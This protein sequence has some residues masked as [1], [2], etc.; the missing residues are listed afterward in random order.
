MTR[1]L[2][3]GYAPVHFVCFKPLYDS[4]VGEPDIE[5]LVSGG[6][7]SRSSDG[8][9][10]HD[11]AAMYDQFDLAPHTVVDAADVGDLDVDILFCSNTKPIKPHSYAL[12]VEMFHGLSFRNRAVRTERVSYDR[13]FILGP[14]QHR[15]LLQRGVI[16]DDAAQGV[17][18]GFPKTDRLVDGSLSRASTLAGLGLSGERSVVLY[19]PTG[20]HENSLET[21]GEELVRRLGASSE[22]DLLVKPHDHAKAAI[23][24][25]D[26]LAPLETDHV[27]LLRSADVIPALHAADLLISD[28]SSIANEYLLLDRPLVFLDV[29]ELLA[30]AADE[31]DR[32]DLDTWGRKGGLVAQD[33]DEA[34]RAIDE[35]LS[36]PDAQSDTRRAIAGDLF[37][38]PGTATSMAVDRLRTEARLLA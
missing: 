35:G 19:A 1:I 32:L 10:H 15:R 4:L 2:F 17:P 33:V 28:A 30:A 29:P 36:K 3:T 13:Y 14:Y 20:A 37:Y 27:R 7:R 11:T 31:D 38:N 16:H 12:S 18:I 21:F 5:I 9:R 23:D 34:L 6:L 24:W 22:F 8:M 26:R 25:F